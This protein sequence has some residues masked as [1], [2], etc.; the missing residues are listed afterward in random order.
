MLMFYTSN[1]YISICSECWASTSL[2][3][4]AAISRIFD[5]NMCV[6]CGTHVTDLLAREIRINNNSNEN[7]EEER[8]KCCSQTCEYM[9]FLCFPTFRTNFQNESNA[10][11]KPF[12]VSVNEMDMCAV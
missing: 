3:L 9:A 12:S 6:A 4:S 7:T 10:R 1:V 8:K 5:V 11:I 2:P